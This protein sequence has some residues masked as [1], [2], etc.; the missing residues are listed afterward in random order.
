MLSKLSRCASS[1]C[2][3][4][5]LFLF[6]VMAVLMTAGG[7]GGST[8]Y[9]TLYVT[10]TASEDVGADRLMIWVVK[11]E[12]TDRI[13]IPRDPDDNPEFTFDV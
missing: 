1:R 10:V 11:G 4:L 9:E 7:C 13:V 3:G 8:T 2:T 5:S 12:G 6:A